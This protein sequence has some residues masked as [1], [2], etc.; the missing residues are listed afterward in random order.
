MYLQEW[1]KEIPIIDSVT[2][3]REK[4]NCDDKMSLD[5]QIVMYIYFIDKLTKINIVPHD[6]MVLLSRC[7]SNRYDGNT[8]EV[9]V[10]GFSYEEIEEA[11]SEILKASKYDLLNI[12]MSWYASLVQGE[13]TLPSNYCF[14]FTPWED[15]L[16]WRV[17]PEN[18]K[19][20]GAAPFGAYIL[21]ELSF[22]G[23]D[24]DSQQERIGELTERVEETNRILELPE[25]EWSKYFTKATDVFKELGF[26]DDR[27]KEEKERD[28]FNMRYDAIYNYISLAKTIKKHMCW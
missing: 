9:S 26:T 10:S 8:F 12:D 16:G 15:S 20:V 5:D 13:G 23:I 6:D 24:E 18:I 2:Y 14:D 21:E 11:K 17:D 3:L 1:L 4:M 7:L 22:N 25:E 27:T 28:D 19:T